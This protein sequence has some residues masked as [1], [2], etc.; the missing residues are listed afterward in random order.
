MFNKRGRELFWDLVVGAGWAFYGVIVLDRAFSGGG[1]VDLGQALFVTILSA[2]FLVRRSARRPGASWE[3]LLALA[4]TFLP[5]A[6][7]RPATGGLRWLG[8]P[9]QV[10]S[11]TGMTAAAITLGRSFGIAPADRGLRTT[12]LYR[13]VRHPLYAMELWF[14]V[15]YFVANPSWRNLIVLGVTGT[16]QIIRI[17]REERILEG[18]DSYAQQVRWRLVQL[19]W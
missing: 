18:Y 16:I 15:G 2:L 11:L 9:I 6:V 10:I 1:L 4:G 13:W 8:Q 19:V 5:P 14:Y 12:G 7:A 3:M 17:T